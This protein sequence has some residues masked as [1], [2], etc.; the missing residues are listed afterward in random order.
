MSVPISIEVATPADR[1]ALLLL[2]TKQFAEHDI[3]LGLEK[4]GYAIDG[5][6]SEPRR[7]RILVARR[8]GQVVGLAAMSYIWTL[9]HGAQTCW[10]DELYVEPTLRE[11]KIGTQ[12]LHAAY[13]RAEADGCVA[14]DLEVEED[15]ARAANLYRREGFLAHSRARFV[16]LLGAARTDPTTSWGNKTT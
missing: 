10:L 8:D 7:G 13:T 9:E 15:H 16:R 14:M 1:D 5:L 11:Q 4:L 6:L 2:L 12:L 3:H